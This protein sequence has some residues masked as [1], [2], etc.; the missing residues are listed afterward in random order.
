M[1]VARLRESGDW[2]GTSIW[3]IS[4]H[5]G[6]QYKGPDSTKILARGRSLAGSGFGL[7]K[8]KFRH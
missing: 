8:E 4:D 5:A 3:F 7:V 6:W 1:A 2:G